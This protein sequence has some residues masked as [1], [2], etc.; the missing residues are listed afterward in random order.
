[1]EKPKLAM[2]MLMQDYSI[3]IKKSFKRYK[4]NNEDP[5]FWQECSKTVS[6]V[7]G[8]EILLSAHV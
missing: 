6:S 3:N 7:K 5:T 8:K 4:T 1:M 2:H